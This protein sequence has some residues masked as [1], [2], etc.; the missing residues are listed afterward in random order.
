MNIFWIVVIIIL[1]ILI[2]GAL[3]YWGV[4]EVLGD[5]IERAFDALIDWG[6]D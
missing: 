4:I 3:I 5:L 2:I 6:E 1:T